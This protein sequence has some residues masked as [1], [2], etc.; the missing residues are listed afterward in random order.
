MRKRLSAAA[1]CEAS[2]RFRAA[3]MSAQHVGSDGGLVSACACDC[4]YT[5]P[6]GYL[7]VYL[8]HNN[9]LHAWL[10]PS[11]YIVVNILLKRQ[12]PL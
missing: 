2:R 8:T 6:T 12:R 5:H 9:M 7:C 10:V 4:L 1:M 3:H 11:P